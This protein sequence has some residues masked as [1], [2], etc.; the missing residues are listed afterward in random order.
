M[1]FHK[2]VLLNETLTLLDIKPGDIII[3]CTLGHGGHT[4]AFLDK[5]A[6]V[7]G[8]DQ[9]PTNLEIVSKRFNSKNFYPI[10][11][12]FNNLSKIATDISQPIAGVFFDLGLNSFQQK[13]TNRGFS[14]NDS[15]SLDMRLDPTVTDLT[16]E[17]IINTYDFEQLNTLLSKTVQEK[18]SKPIA[19]AI[20]KNRQSHPIKSGQRLA[21]IIE[22]VYHQYHLHSKIHPATK[23]FLALRIEVNNEFENIKT[24]LQA[25]TGLNPGCKV[26]WIS[27]HSGEDRIIKNFI[28]T[29][30]LVTLTNKP[31]APSLEEIKNNPLSRSSLLRSY[32]IN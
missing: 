22:D 26:L 18:L 32:R 8:I 16:A 25:T 23:T 9:D 6:V 29:N 28:R 2:P 24:A 10:H 14:F 20:I 4:Q 1:D 3:D 21:S 11:D 15:Q 17:Y 13:A 5:E 30:N 12:N 7:Y 27:F 31:V 19:I